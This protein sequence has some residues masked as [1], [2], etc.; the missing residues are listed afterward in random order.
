M[1]G[2][3]KAAKIKELHEAMSAILAG[4]DSNA[5]RAELIVR[6]AWLGNVRLAELA[7]AITR[8]RGGLA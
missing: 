2:I 6:A 4:I 7:D 8:E 3:D 1:T 5:Q